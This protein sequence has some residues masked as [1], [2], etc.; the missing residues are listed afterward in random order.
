MYKYIRF[1]TCFV[2]SFCYTSHPATALFPTSHPL[3]SLPHWTTTLLST[4]TPP[5]ALSSPLSH[6]SLSLL[7]PPTSSYLRISAFLLYLANPQSLFHLYEPSRQP[8]SI[9]SQTQCSRH[10]FFG[11]K[12]SLVI[13][14][15]IFS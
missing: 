4:S 13:D 15:G 9:L 14:Y 11:K 10:F 6:H 3:L 1:E 5:L 8:A 12:C 2:F 7:L